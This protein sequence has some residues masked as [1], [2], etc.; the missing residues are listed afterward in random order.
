M[1]VFSPSA[2]EGTT[3]NTVPVT[4]QSRFS[5]STW[6][7]QVSVCLFPN[8]HKCFAKCLF[9]RTHFANPLVAIFAHSLCAFATFGQFLS[10]VKDDSDALDKIAKDMK[11][12]SF[13]LGIYAA[14]KPF[15][16][17]FTTGEFGFSP[18]FFAD[19]WKAPKIKK[20]VR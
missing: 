10:E 11:V 15:K 13:S 9:R 5:A 7:N 3:E 6:P 12:Y 14:I 17:P 4:V 8:V 1:N 19:A 20:T 16:R 2:S 18:Q